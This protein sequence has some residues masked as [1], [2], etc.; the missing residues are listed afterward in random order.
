MIVVERK[1]VTKVS[2]DIVF[3]HAWQLRQKYSVDAIE[4]QWGEVEFQLS[5]YYQ[6]WKYARLY[7]YIW[8]G[9]LNSKRA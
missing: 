4:P 7:I 5:G 2:H 1:K 3:R 9:I 6:K 8:E